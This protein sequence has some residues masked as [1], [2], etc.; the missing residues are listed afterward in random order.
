MGEKV[1]NNPDTLIPVI[2]RAS[3]EEV[4]PILL[5]TI[6]N[7]QED[8]DKGKRLAQKVIGQYSSKPAIVRK[9]VVRKEG[10]EGEGETVEFSSFT[11][12]EMNELRGLLI[13]GELTDIDWL[14]H[15]YEK[16]GHTLMVSADELS[17]VID[18]I[19]HPKLRE[20]LLKDIEQ[21]G[22][23]ALASIWHWVSKA[24]KKSF[25]HIDFSS[26]QFSKPWNNI[27][28]LQHQLRK[29]TILNGIYHGDNPW[30]ATNVDGIIR[31]LIKNAP[32][33]YKIQ[34]QNLLAGS[35]TPNEIKEKIT[36]HQDMITD[37]KFTFV[38]KEER[39]QNYSFFHRKKEGNKG[40]PEYV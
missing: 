11:R 28:Q 12:Q 33:G 29:L 25:P 16:G 19:E 23:Q 30:E 37:K 7:L 13:K 2:Q 22:R 8:N 26:S 20:Q 24:W 36:L 1:T 40:T 4:I 34:M 15:L 39:T 3:P 10:T 17:Q 35:R 6:H 32:E 27:G 38:A 9:K 18:A 5:H 21:Q 14:L 31:C